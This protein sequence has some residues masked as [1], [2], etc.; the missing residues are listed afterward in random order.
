MTSGLAPTR[1]GGL[2]RS[3]SRVTAE[4]TGELY[5]SAHPS[6]LP[7]TH[8][9]VDDADAR[10][11]TSQRVRRAAEPLD[12]AFEV[13]EFIGCHEE[14]V[15][16]RS[17]A[18]RCSTPARIVPACDL[19]H[20]LKA[21]RYHEQTSGYRARGARCSDASW[22]CSAFS[23]QFQPR[24]PSAALMVGPV[25][26]GC[27]PNCMVPRQALRVHGLLSPRAGDIGS[28]CQLSLA[29]RRASP[30]CSLS[31]IS[32]ITAPVISKRCGRCG[33]LERR[34]RPWWGDHAGVHQVSVLFR[35]GIAAVVPRHLP[36]AP[37]LHMTHA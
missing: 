33:V 24:S 35:L 4:Y 30:A 13:A 23:L 14:T 16:R 7:R 15:R 20:E 22:K 9:R 29:A 5:R 21:A 17:R 37:S 36:V 10:P 3:P 27:R 12:D 18:R 6:R 25:G 1:G 2:Q 19:R 28:S 31:E 26:S 32:E 34:A 11:R 8:N